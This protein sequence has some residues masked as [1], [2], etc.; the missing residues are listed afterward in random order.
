MTS[1]AFVQALTA[2]MIATVNPCGFAMLPAY[3]SFFLGLE[4][5]DA[6]PARS[7]T[8][9]AGRAAVVSLAVSGGFVLVFLVLGSIFRAGVSWVADV[10]VWLTPLIGLVLVALGVAMLFGIRLAFMIPKLDRGGRT[11]GI[12]SMFTF[13]VSYAIASLGCTLAPFTSVV[14]AAGKRRGLVSAGWGFLVYGAGFAIVLGALTVSL[15]LARGGLL[16]LLRKALRYV[17]QAA[18]VLLI[19]SGLYVAWYGYTEISN[20]TSRLTASGA[21]WSAQLSTWMQTNYRS[22]AIVFALVLAATVATTVV[23]RRR[24]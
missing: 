1:A 22:T 8:T 13:G 14:F 18:A 23:R 7:T 21:N 10:A 15:A 9:R 20:R 12:A 17:D 5:A 3:L 19:L 16:G 11:Q 4:S 2:G 24:A 6:A